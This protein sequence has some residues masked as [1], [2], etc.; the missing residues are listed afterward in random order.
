MRQT[1]F[2]I[3]LDGPWGIGSFELPGFGFGIVLA[4]WCLFGIVWLFRNPSQRAHLKSM[5]SPAGT[6]L[7]I[8]VAIVLVPWFVQRTSRQEIAEADRVLQSSPNSPDAFIARAQAHFNKLDYTQAVDDLK[9]AIRVSPQSAIAINRLAWIQATCPRASVRD[10][11]AALENAKEACALTSSRN[12]EYLATLAAAEAET[13]DF[14]EAVAVDRQ[15]LRL[16]SSITRTE[17][18]A[19]LADLPRMREQ[20]QAAEQGRPFRDHSAGKTLPV[21]GFGAMLFLGFTAGAWSAARRGQLV[22]LSLEM[23]W[24]IAIWLFIAGVVGCRVFYCIQYAQ[25]VFFDSKNGEYVLKSL[26]NMVF[27]AVNLPDGGLVWYGGL[28]AG[29]LGAAWLCRQ[30]KL[31]FLEVGDVLIPSLFLGLAFGRI[32]CFLNGC[33][34]GDQ[35]TLPWGVHFPMGSVPDMSLVLRGYLGADQDFSLMLH[36]TQ[37]YSSLNAFILFF[38][39]STYFYYR[40]RNGAVIALGALTYAI[41]RF[42]IEFLRDDEVGQFGTSLTISQWLSIV[43]FIFAVGFSAWLSRQPLLRRPTLR[44]PAAGQPVTA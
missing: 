30:R 22:G 11:A 7:L 4:L 1:L 26:P 27:S 8:A 23:M 43:M 14:K 13:G 37:L 6:W 12:P 34:Y 28:F 24:D 32:G 36:P 39:T 25:R 41:T 5:V 16:V 33:C 31:S 19:P 18:A 9:E 35:C 38:L 40:P 21:Y 29:V 42:T 3:P 17:E 10:G 44:V 2:R 15:A 20:L